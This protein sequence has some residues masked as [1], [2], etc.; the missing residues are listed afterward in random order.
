MISPKAESLLPL[1]GNRHPFTIILLL[2]SMT[3]SGCRASQNAPDQDTDLKGTAEKTL[4][5][6]NI[7]VLNESGTFALCRQKPGLDHARRQYRF[8]VIR[9]KDNAIVHDGTFSMGYVKW[10]DDQSIEVVSGSPS[11][12]EGGTKEII[13]VNSPVQ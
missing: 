13:H 6:E 7:I 1:V 10:L 12:K 3:L 2:V 9:L 4:G 11:L 5:K 8:V